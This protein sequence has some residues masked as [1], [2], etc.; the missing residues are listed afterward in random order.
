[1]PKV[2]KEYFE[3]K[4][5]FIIDAAIRVCKTKPVYEV[6]L[7]DVIKEGGISPGAMYC[8]FSCVDEIFAAILNRCYRE[9]NLDGGAGRIFEG[10]DSPEAIIEA[11]FKCMGQ[12]IEKASKPYGKII[13]ELHTVFI[14]NPERRKRI[15]ALLTVE[16]DCNKIDEMLIEFIAAHI[17]NGYFKPSTPKPYILLL[18]GIAVQGVISSIPLPDDVK[19]DFF[20]LIGL[21]Q[22]QRGEQGMAEAISRMVV[23][24]LKN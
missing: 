12:I 23:N 13:N 10:G 3:K 22:A 4:E 20:D 21:D 15:N 16:S 17:E 11:A 2:G 18:V 9:T 5:N 6:T 24:L 14:N 19:G 1:M 7:R 8:Y